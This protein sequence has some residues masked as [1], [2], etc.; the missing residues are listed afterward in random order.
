MINNK[1]AIIIPAFSDY[2]QIRR[3]LESLYNNQHSD[4]DAVIVDHCIIDKII[5]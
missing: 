3:C 2:E 5:R 4:F 1:L